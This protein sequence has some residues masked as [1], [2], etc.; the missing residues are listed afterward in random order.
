MYVIFINRKKIHAQRKFAQ[1]LTPTTPVEMPSKPKLKVSP[2]KLF[3]GR[4]K[5]E[6]FLTYLCFRGEKEFL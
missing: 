6:D 3:P 4:P 2:I 5:T 1:G